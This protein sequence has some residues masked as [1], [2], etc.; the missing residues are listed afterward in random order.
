MFFDDCYIPRSFF[1]RK[2]LWMQ[3]EEDL[4]FNRSRDWYRPYGAFRRFRRRPWVPKF[5]DDSFFDMDWP[6]SRKTFPSTSFDDFCQPEEIQVKLLP[7]KRLE[8]RGNTED[9]GEKDGRSFR[10]SRKFYH[11]MDVP[12][13]MDVDGLQSLMNKN[14]ELVISRP[15][16]TTKNNVER[17]IEIQV[18]PREKQSLKITEL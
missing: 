16:P 17:I 4:F 13:N 18:E 10:C 11:S 9:S 7:D 14:N 5:Y 6:F 3:I 15:R 2:P 8:I 1:L 12:D